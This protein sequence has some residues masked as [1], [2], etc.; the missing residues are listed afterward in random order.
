MGWRLKA[1]VQNII[2]SLPF[3]NATYYLVQ[4]SL[5]SLRP[6]RRDPREWLTA[7]V[8]MVNWIRSYGRDVAGKSFLEV[9]TGRAIDL[10]LGLWLCGASHVLTVDLNRYLSS[11]VV[12]ES[13]K[14]L[15]DHRDQ[16]ASIFDGIEKDD[17][18]QDRFD[19]LLNFNGGLAD[20]LR[21]TR[22][23]YVSPAD[24][25]HLSVDSGSFD[26]H[27]SYTVMEH[28]PP[29]VIVAILLEARRLLKP[30][31]LLL[32]HIDCSDHFSHS[33]KSISAINFLQFSEAEWSKLAGN[34]FMYH[35]R[36]RAYEYIELFKCAGVK[37]IRERQAIDENSL[38]ILKNGF[39]LHERFRGLEPEKLAASSITI[40]GSFSEDT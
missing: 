32:H 7:A 30:D 12:K 23:E 19:R 16:I 22:I 29:E 27:I 17:L 4:R 13:L 15:H 14:F 28:I 20:L 34:Q 26:F 40:M 2:A 9:G 36:L 8:Q 39:R 35:N 11:A 10:P 24:A 5:G 21:M 6:G 18:F 33:D 38:Q 31:G 1:M 37:I 25:A 3:S